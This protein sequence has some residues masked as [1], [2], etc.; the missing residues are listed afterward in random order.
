MPNEQQ[1]DLPISD[2][3]HAAGVSTPRPP[4]SRR[5]FVLTGG[6]LLLTAVAE[7]CTSEGM[8]SQRGVVRLS[9]VGLAPGAPSGGTATI[10]RARGGPTV[11]VDVPPIGEAT[12]PV[13]IGDYS[14]VYAPPAGY[15][16]LSGTATETRNIEVDFDAMTTASFSIIEQ[17]V[18][19][20]VQITVSG[21]SGAVGGT[22]TLQRTDVAAP[23]R[24]LPVSAA[25]T[26]SNSSVAA[27]TYSVSYTAPPGFIDVS[28]ANPANGVVVTA[29]ATAAVGFAVAI[30][31]GS[32]H[33]EVAGLAGA[34]SGGRITAIQISTGA[35]SVVDLSA[36]T[37]G[38]TTADLPDVPSGSY[39]LT[40]T[41]PAG[42]ELTELSP[43]SRSITVPPAGVANVN[44]D[45]RPIPGSLGVTVTGLT[46]AV[47]GGQVVL[48]NSTSGAAS[49]LNL[50]SA[51]AGSSTGQ[52]AGLAPGS[53]SAAYTPPL[54]FQLTSAS[55]VAVTIASQATAAVNFSVIA[56]D[57]T[58]RLVVDGLDP[59]AASG[60]SAEILR[61]D[62]P[63]QTPFLVAIPLIGTVDR[64]LQPGSY[65]VTYTAPANHQLNAGQANPRDVMVFGN[66]TAIAA[67]SVVVAPADGT[68]RV[69]VQGLLPS[70]VDGGAI[71]VLRTDVAGQA[72]Q[73][74]T[75]PASGSL[76]TPRT[77]G[78]YSVT[79][80]A[81]GGHQLVAGQ[82]NPRSAAVTSSQTATVSFQVEEIPPPAGVIFHSDF[83]T[84]LGTSDAAVMDTG[85]GAPWN[86]RGG[87]GLE[88]ISSAG[89]DFPMPNVLRVM[90]L[91]STSGFAIV[92]K[93]GMPVP[94]V[95]QSRYYRWYIRAGANIEDN[96][97][98]PIQDGQN[99]GASNWQ[100]ELLHTLGGTNRWTIQFKHAAVQQNFLNQ[101]F[102]G[103]ALDVN[104]TYRIEVHL[105]RTSNTAYNF[106]VRVYNSANALL[107]TDANFTNVDQGI[108]HL[109]A[110]NTGQFGFGNANN[111][112]GLNGGCNGVAPLSGDRLYSYQSGFAV[113]G[114]DWIGPY[115]GGI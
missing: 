11:S 51:S 5:G 74:F 96:N 4:V 32:I 17:A 71:S 29:G 52:L 42:F 49:T 101:N 47:G 20:T 59:A 105:L 24:F 68:L 33:V 25:G 99:A 110:Q 86:L 18:V 9:L 26:A 28:A 78:A 2:G 65:R 12:V 90:A 103:P 82:Q 56:V 70:A 19:G 89:L 114:T 61:T 3:D 30:A 83:G 10:T 75:I 1:K 22:A 6:S 104:V 8:R 85:K 109:G 69:T 77:P 27:G 113:S 64:S 43:A 81:P 39:S 84:A 107:Y 54:G 73:N 111:L 53:Y 93:T 98:H 58:I 115:A 88:V 87:Q 102:R 55:P 80:V 62:I 66:Q 76:D 63:G 95:G 112:D 94:A 60:G 46:G 36:P 97:T 45:G 16:L 35:T 100:F 92:R 72:A 31:P 50:P 7:A 57:G 48:T 106:H 79:Y 38:L 108:P 13:D 23:P 40:Y 91:T 67:F 14:V 34:S 41:P 15:V 37:S 21:L 44:F